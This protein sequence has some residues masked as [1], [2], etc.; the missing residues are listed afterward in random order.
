MHQKFSPMVTAI[1]DSTD[2]LEEW[3]RI[4]F[5]D[6]ND[7]TFDTIFWDKEIT[8]HANSESAIFLRIK[9]VNGNVVVDE[10]QVSPGKSVKLDSLKNDEKY[11]FEIKA[12]Q[13][14]SFIVFV[15]FKLSQ[16]DHFKS[17]PLYYL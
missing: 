8:N 13:G 11:F 1:V 14:R 10:F 15:N 2:N 16:S 7:L 12:T 6:R 9:D 3:E 17:E 4:S 5:N